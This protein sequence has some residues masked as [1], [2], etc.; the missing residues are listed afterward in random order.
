[1]AGT[2]NDR[3]RRCRTARWLLLLR[4]QGKKLSSSKL[5]RRSFNQNNALEGQLAQLKHDRLRVQRCSRG[6]R[7]D[8]GRAADAEVFTYI[9]Q[10]SEVVRRPE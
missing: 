3:Y 1:M 2:G 8:N 6:R 5:R 10:I 9:Q 7:T 4:P